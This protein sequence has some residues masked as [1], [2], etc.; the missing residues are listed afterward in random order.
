MKKPRKLQISNF[1]LHLYFTKF[2]VVDCG[3]PSSNLSITNKIYY[4]G[5]PPLITKYLQSIEI[6]C[7]MGYLYLDGSFRKN[8]SCSENGVWLATIACSRKL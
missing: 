7:A 8:Q 3:D 1:K 2:I 6:S 5:S 4:T